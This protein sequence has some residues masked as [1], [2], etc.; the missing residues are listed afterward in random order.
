MVTSWSEDPTSSHFHLGKTKARYLS[1]FG[2]FP[3]LREEFMRRLKESHYF[4]LSIDGS[5]NVTV[6]NLRASVP[7]FGI[8]DLLGDGKKPFLDFCKTSFW[9]F[10]SFFHVFNP[11]KEESIP[12]SYTTRC[13]TES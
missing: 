8:E 12:P 1:L 5:F 4:G 3:Y 9:Q 10:S 6:E 7:I 11:Q 13:V 2:V